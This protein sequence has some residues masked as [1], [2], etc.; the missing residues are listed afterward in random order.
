MCCVYFVRTFSFFFLWN[1]YLL[2]LIG[3]KLVFP[4]SCSSLLF[5]FTLFNWLQIQLMTSVFFLLNYYFLYSSF[6]KLFF[7]FSTYEWVMWMSPSFRQK[8]KK[9]LEGKEANQILFAD[10]LTW[11]LLFLFVCWNNELF[12]R[13]DDASSQLIVLLLCFSL[14]P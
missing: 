2:Y 13:Y 14:T 7:N 9:I 4:V 6:F 8:Q 1:Y 11:V 12:I 10:W 5:L 3:Y